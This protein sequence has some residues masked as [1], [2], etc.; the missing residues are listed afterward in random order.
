MTSISAMNMYNRFGPLP[1]KS[2]KALL[3]SNSRARLCGY[4]SGPNTWTGPYIYAIIDLCD[5]QTT[6]H[7]YDPDNELCHLY[8]GN[9]EM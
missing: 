8:P 9:E 5:I 6:V 3:E 2:G 4:C 7:A 1:Y